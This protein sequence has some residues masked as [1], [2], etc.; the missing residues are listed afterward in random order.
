MKAV[1]GKKGARLGDISNMING[2]QQ[3]IN[4]NGLL[5]LGKQICINSQCSI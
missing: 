3:I 5:L 1:N 2:R 4:M